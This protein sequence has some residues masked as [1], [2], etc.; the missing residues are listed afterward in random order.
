MS[1]KILV[2]D[3]DNMMHILYQ[4]HFRDEINKGL[5]Q[6]YFKHS[7]VDALDFIRE[8]ELDYVLSDVNMP[9]MTGLELLKIVKEEKPE[10]D[11]VIISAFDNNREEAEALKAT[12]FL[13]KPIK[14]DD[15]KELI[16]K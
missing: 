14:M 9:Q 7:A 10:L 12:L 4:A 11:V 5:A 15:L 2:V 1:K 8:E 3:D 13:Q 6:F 16:F